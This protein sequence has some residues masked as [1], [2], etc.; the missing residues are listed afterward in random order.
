MG[1]AESKCIT[2]KT[3]SIYVDELIYY[4]IVIF[5]FYYYILFHYQVQLERV[6][7]LT[8]SSNSSLACDPN[9]GTIAYPTGYVVQ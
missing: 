3:L 8:A 2:H 6:L 9:T 5:F 7:G 1:Y 4:I